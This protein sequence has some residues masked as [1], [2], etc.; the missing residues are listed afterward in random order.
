MYRFIYSTSIFYF[1]FDIT[2]KLDVRQYYNHHNGVFTPE[3]DND[4][5]TRQKLNLCI[6]MMSFTPAMS[7]LA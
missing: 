7:D 1:I 5:T 2:Y 6:P 4:K 3:Q